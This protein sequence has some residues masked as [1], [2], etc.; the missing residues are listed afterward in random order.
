MDG[1]V[2]KE[3]DVSFP[4]DW[5]DLDKDYTRRGDRRT[6]DV[7]AQYP[8]TG[9]L[10]EYDDSDY[11]TEEERKQLLRDIERQVAKQVAYG[12]M[13]IDDLTDADSDNNARCTITLGNGSQLE[14]KYR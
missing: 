5:L 1:K 7:P 13:S 14:T 10:F 2:I 3:I 4:E 6:R 9:V 8:D 11:L 12:F